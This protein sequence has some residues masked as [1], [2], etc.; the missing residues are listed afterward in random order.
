MKKLS[1]DTFLPYGYVRTYRAK[2]GRKAEKRSAH[3]PSDSQ[4]R[5]GRETTQHVN[6]GA[7]VKSPID[8]RGHGMMYYACVSRKRERV[9]AFIGLTMRK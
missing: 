9:D 6:S 3:I 1:G 4:Q 5:H 8:D 2:F 7:V